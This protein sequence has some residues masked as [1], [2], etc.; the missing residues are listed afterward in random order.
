MPQLRRPRVPLP[1]LLDIPL[2]T[3]TQ[4]VLLMLGLS[5]AGIIGGSAIWRKANRPTN[6][7]IQRTTNAMHALAII[8]F[9]AIV[10]GYFGFWIL[11]LL[12]FAASILM[13]G[14]M[15]G[16]YIPSV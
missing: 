5:L 16:G 15:L 10:V 12:L 6:K 11:G 4:F 14:V 8:I 3:G 7:N 13:M 1:S 9:S 2:L